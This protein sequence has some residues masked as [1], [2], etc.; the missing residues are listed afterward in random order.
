MS[1]AALIVVDVQRDFCEGG[2]LAAA[3]TLSLLNPLQEFIQSARRAG[4]VTVYTQDWHPPDHNSFQ[5]NGGPWPVHCV[6]NTPG[7]QIMPPLKPEAEDIIIHKGVT[8]DGAGYSGFESTGLAKRLKELKIE[9]LAVS[10]IATEYCVRATA[11]DGVQ[12]GFEITVLTDMIRAVRP[13][14]TS[15]VLTEL[16]QSGAKPAAAPEWIKSLQRRD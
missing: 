15:R 9:R 3:D 7:A 8:A 12:A 6:A 4:A 16:S 11:L 1:K 2:A 14:E 13:S 10:G 5:S